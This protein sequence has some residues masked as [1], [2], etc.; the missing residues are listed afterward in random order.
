M[1]WRPCVELSSRRSVS[2]FA[3]SAVD[4]IDTTPP[5]INA[6]LQSTPSA[7]A[8]A[9][10]INIVAPTW[11]APRPNTMRRIVMSRGRLNS[12]PMLNI[13]KTT[14]ISASSR[15]SSVAGIQASA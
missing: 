1:I 2:S 11:A 5:N 7:A 13:R 10:A 9:Q 4:D 3:S 15:A 6:A 12:S 8:I 14:P